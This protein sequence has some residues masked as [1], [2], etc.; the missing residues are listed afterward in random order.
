MENFLAALWRV[1]ENFASVFL[2]RAL[3]PADFSINPSLADG[4]L[5]DL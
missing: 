3:M 1:S 2:G 4:F 5:G